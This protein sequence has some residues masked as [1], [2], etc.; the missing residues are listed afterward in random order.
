MG[1]ILNRSA[2][3]IG[4]N[5]ILASC[6]GPVNTRIFAWFLLGSVLKCLSTM[7]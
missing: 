5:S 3:R 7:K 1:E 6:L 4:A 2:F